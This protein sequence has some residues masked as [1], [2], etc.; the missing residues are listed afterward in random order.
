MDKRGCMMLRVMINRFNPKAGNALLKFFSKEEAQEIVN[1]GIQSTD[2]A[3]IVQQPQKA[4]ST[5]HY[6]W[7]QPLLQTFPPPLQPV[8]IAALT[9]EQIAGMKISSPEPISEVA[10]SYILNQ[11]YLKLNIRDH[12]PIEYLPE[13][14]LSPLAKFSKEKLVNICDY[15][16]LYDLA[17]EVRHIVNRNYLKNIYACLTPQQF[18]YLKLCL[19]QKDKLVSPK[20]G[21]DPSKQD[22]QRL[23]QILHRRGLV[24]LGKALCGQ[25]PDLIW[26][27]AHVF[28]M[29]RGNILLKE[30]NVQELP[31]VTKI[32]KQELFNILNFLEKGV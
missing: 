14:D 21:I 13:T 32:L 9:P 2:L 26:H 30:F 19:H 23:N 4:I 20:L 12:F 1:I 24:R 5:I 11:L 7:I 3:P 15:F 25:H 29:N 8:V 22:C 16:G 17:S 18:Y 27:I 10:R 31:K 6:S 28:D